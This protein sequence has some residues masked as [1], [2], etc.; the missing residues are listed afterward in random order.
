MTYKSKF[1]F[2]ID[3][4]AIKNESIFDLFYPEINEII[5]HNYS[6]FISSSPTCNI[7]ISE[8]Q[9]GLSIEEAIIFLSNKFYI[10]LENSTYD[11][12]FLQ[13]LLREFKSK[14]KKINNH[15]ENGWLDFQMGG[16]AE[17]IIPFL[18]GKDLKTYRCFVLVDSDKEFPLE[19][20]KK[21]VLE[22]FCITNNIPYHILEKRE[23][24]NYM[25]SDIVENINLLS[26]SIKSYILL[27]S[28][29]KD[30][31]DLENGYAMSRPNLEIRKKLVHTFYSDVSDPNYDNLRNG[32]KS[33]FQNFKKE[34]SEL[35]ISATQEGLLQRTA[36]QNNPNELR[37]IL[38]KITIQL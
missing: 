21:T 4:G 2:F 27:N 33:E 15:K 7:T 10:I 34:F 35:F 17:N 25:P 8:N 1:N 11:A 18:N 9:S 19:S 30:F 13:A 26:Q 6:L 31:F 38:Q 37:D 24:E 23:M 36:E 28:A 20:N 14:S 16:G 5:S 12:H 29:Q 3:I 22:N 32:L